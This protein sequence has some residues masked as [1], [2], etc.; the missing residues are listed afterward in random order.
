[1]GPH[2]AQDFRWVSCARSV[3]GLNRESKS[4]TPMKLRTLGYIHSIA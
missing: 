3:T 1:M 4:Y 2:L